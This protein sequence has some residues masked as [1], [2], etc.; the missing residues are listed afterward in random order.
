MVVAT[1]GII[2]AMHRTRAGTYGLT[3]EGTSR[4]AH[5]PRGPMGPWAQ[6]PWAQGPGP[7]G[8]GPGPW[9][10]D[11]WARSWAHGPWPWAHGPWPWAHGPG[12]GPMG[13]GPGPMGLVLSPRSG[14]LKITKSTSALEKNP[15]SFRSTRID[16]SRQVVMTQAIFVHGK[17]H[18]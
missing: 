14:K 16:P 2:S 4:L 1:Q 13:P 6:G 11:P 5:G 17:I 15:R 7:M 9:P 8:P 12:P 3:H 18:F 10:W